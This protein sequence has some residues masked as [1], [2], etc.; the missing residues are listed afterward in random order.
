MVLPTGSEDVKY[1]RHPLLS[2]EGF[3]QLLAALFFS[4]YFF[5]WAGQL[6]FIYTLVRLGV[7]T[8]AR[9]LLVSLMYI[10]SIIVWKPQNRRGWP[11][12]WFLYSPF[13][14]LVLGYYSATCVREGP[15]LDPKGKYLFAMS[16]HGIF[17]VCR[18]FSGGSQW[19]TL[20]PGITARWGSFGG[21]FFIP[22]VRE[23]SLCCGCI[24]A[25]RPVLEKAAKR[26]ENLT[27][28]PGGI[29]EMLLTD[30][31]STTTKLV[32]QDRKGFVKLA[33]KYGLQLV[34]GFCLGEKWV[35]DIVLLP[36]WLR[37]ILYRFRLA[38]TLLR[39]RWW[40]FL[41]KVERIDGSPIA[42]GYVW[43]QPIPVRHDPSCPP[44]Y[45]DQVHAAYM[46][47]VAALFERHKLRFGY[48]AEETLQYVKSTDV[49][50][51][52]DAPPRKKRAPKAE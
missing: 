32:L 21:A 45:V 8:Q 49:V 41:G 16:P 18:A 44:E 3:L 25:S 38:G 33:V 13:V 10:A 36:S 12:E 22:G 20:F 37:T 39:G 2:P 23:F 47:A 34:P 31:S 7:L 4:A 9:G 43:G 19:R 30:G 6:W 24:D 42:L 52:K 17:G 28:I 1:E 26:G 35:H 51:R 48:A 46:E 50:S 15:P 14:D 40:T 11:F 29:K 5:F 27:L